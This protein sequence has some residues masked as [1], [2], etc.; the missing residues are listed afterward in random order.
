M[1]W[2]P[3]SK[4]DRGSTRLAYDGSGDLEYYAINTIDGIDVI[5]PT[6]QVFK[7]VRAEGNLSYV[8]GP[9]MGAWDNRASLGWS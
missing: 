1:A 6:W 5:L 3:S 9:L 2:D 8:E 7:L 4:A